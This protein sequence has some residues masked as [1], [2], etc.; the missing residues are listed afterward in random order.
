MSII[1]IALKLVAKTPDPKQE[2]VT[3]RQNS[4]LDLQDRNSL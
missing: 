2:F 3:S 4:E 1:H